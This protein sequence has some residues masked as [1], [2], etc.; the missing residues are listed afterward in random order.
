[1]LPEVTDGCKGRGS[2]LVTFDLLVKVS[3]NFV[4]SILSSVRLGLA[5]HF[6]TSR[7]YHMP[8]ARI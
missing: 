5:L 1:M 6:V 7:Q 2:K 8:L 4:L 3:H